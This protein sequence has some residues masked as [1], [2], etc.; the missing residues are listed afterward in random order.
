MLYIYKSGFN[1]YSVVINSLG[2]VYCTL[3][4]LRTIIYIYINTGTVYM[5]MATEIIK[6]DTSLIIYHNIYM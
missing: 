5:Y 2:N 1:L 3:C 6:S 4:E